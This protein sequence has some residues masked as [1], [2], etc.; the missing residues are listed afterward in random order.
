MMG[1][2][3]G[4]SSWYLNMEAW[5]SSEV[6]MLDADGGVLDGYLLSC[7]GEFKNPSAGSSVGSPS[8]TQRLCLHCLVLTLVRAVM[9]VMRDRIAWG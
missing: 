8:T 6:Q 7:S 5:V 9:T 4:L 2:F 3:L 1:G